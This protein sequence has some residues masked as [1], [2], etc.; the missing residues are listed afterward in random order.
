LSLV[1]VGSVAFDSIQTPQGEAKDILGGAA[2][3]FSVTASYFTHV[4]VVAVV[5]EDF[6]DEHLVV[7]H[8]RGIDTAG[9]ERARGKTFRWAAEYS[10]DM[11]EAR[12]LDTQLNV[13]EH[14][15]PKVPPA[16]A[17]SEFLFLANIQPKLQLQV[18]E[19]FPSARVVAMDTMNFWIKGTLDDL[20][21]TLRRV[22]IL[23]INETEAR[24]L[25]G[26]HNLVKAAKVV[27]SL[28]PHLV[29]IKRGE[30]GVISFNGDSIFSVPAYPLEDVHDPTGAGDSFAGGFMGHLARSGE[31]SEQNLR[32]AMVYGSVMASFAVEE[33]GLQRTARLTTGEIEARY[34]EFKS[35]THFDV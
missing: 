33:F 5:G 16:Y 28:G 31:L 2:T 25:A 21:A 14:F 34:R 8:N 13:F 30:Y 7:F 11:N 12:T 23:A 3:H 26:C 6:R 10:G 19:Q 9:L 32:R 15:A 4:K 17:D 22:D 20:K 24:M 18:R 29:I 27:Q 35:L 1:V